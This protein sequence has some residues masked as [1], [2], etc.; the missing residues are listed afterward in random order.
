MTPHLNPDETE[1]VENVATPLPPQHEPE[2][3]DDTL[4]G[5]AEGGNHDFAAV[6]VVAAATGK[7]AARM[8]TCNHNDETTT[9][10]V[11]LFSAS[12][13]IHT[14]TNSYAPFLQ[15]LSLLVT[16]GLLLYAHLGLSAVILS[17]QQRIQDAEATTESS[18][19]DINATG[20][21]N[22]ND[23][24]R[25]TVGG[26]AL[27]KS[28]ESN[29]CAKGYACFLDFDC[30]TTCMSTVFHYSMPCASCFA[31]IPQCSLNDGCAAVCQVQDG[32]SPDCAACTVRCNAIFATCSGLDV[33]L[34]KQN[35][36]NETLDNSTMAPQSS[37]SSSSSVSVETPA[38]VCARQQEGIHLDTVATRHVVYE[39]QF[40]QALQTAW[41]SQAPWLAI[42]IGVFS[43]VWP[44]IKCC[45]MVGLYI[46]PLSQS[47]RGT[48]LTWLRRCGKYTLVDIYVRRIIGCVNGGILCVFIL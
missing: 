10:K 43:G 34:A 22:E 37:S 46:V 41:H 18:N 14:S 4:N 28:R 11:S 30:T 32:T 26:G 5:L 23:Q 2:M 40:I 25:W 24:Y 44:Y 39:I 13:G 36:T 16:I 21:C 19:N 8:H 38:Q 3:N 45:G 47:Q 42:L 20:L 33:S 31:Q 27:N 7:G 6:A 17:N 9:A 29:Y 15:A 48:L 12:Q 1:N 35:V